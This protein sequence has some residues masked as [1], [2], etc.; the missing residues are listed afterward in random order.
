MRIISAFLM[1][2]LALG[3]LT[4]CCS[5]KTF[6]VVNIV[7]EQP[8][9]DVGVVM[10][11]PSLLPFPR[12]ASNSDH[13][14]EGGVLRV[15]RVCDG[16][17]LIFTAQGRGGL[18]I[19][20]FEPQLKFMGIA[21]KPALREA[22]RR[23]I[24]ARKDAKVLTIPVLPSVAYLDGQGNLSN[25]TD[26]ERVTVLS[27]TG[28]RVGDPEVERMLEFINLRFIHIAGTSMTDAGLLKL[29]QKSDL[30]SIDLNNNARITEAGVAQ[31]RAALPN[32]VIIRS[33]PDQESS[34]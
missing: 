34:P 12:G 11:R 33:S 32:A 10:T 9:P 18:T 8:E 13:A 1:S 30:L 20:A 3:T 14:K 22:L 19:V 16:D 5:P 4:S 29:A 26:A 24:N 31:L 17:H 21:G 2:T 27:S 28:E 6:K 7:T 23:W 25:V 15:E